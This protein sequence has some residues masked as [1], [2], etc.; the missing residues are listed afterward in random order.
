MPS[1][2]QSFESKLLVFSFVLP[3]FGK[4]WE[5]CFNY[6]FLTDS[7]YKTIYSTHIR[8]WR[9]QGF[10]SGFLS[11]RSV[12]SFRTCIWDLWKGEE[13][14]QHTDGSLLSNYILPDWPGWTFLLIS[15]DWITHEIMLMHSAE[16]MVVDWEQ[17]LQLYIWGV[18]QSAIFGVLLA[19][20]FTIRLLWAARLMKRNHHNS[21]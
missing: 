13:Y 2:C 20:F 4:N 19:F 11:K 17:G 7:D 16:A 6:A 8:K 15:S 3:S 14:F 12:L 10:L 1:Q 21:I 18:F 9:C 5:I